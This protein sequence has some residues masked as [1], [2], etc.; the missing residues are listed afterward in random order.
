MRSLGLL[1]LVF[2]FSTVCA[3]RL[4]LIPLDS[5]PSSLDVPQMMADTTAW[6]VV[7]PPEDLLGKFL[8]PGNP[9][10][11]IAWLRQGDFQEGDVLIVSADML[12]YGGLVASR[13]PAVAS[14]TALKRLSILQEIK[15]RHPRITIYVFSALMRT[16]PTATSR[17]REWRDALTRYVELEDRYRRTKNQSLLPTLRSLKA[18]IPPDER[19]RYFLA[20]AR[21]MRVHHEL[22]KMVQGK[23]IDY[24]VIGADDARAYG[25]QYQELTELKSAAEQQGIGGKVYFL[26]GID[27]CGNLLISRAVLRRMD[28]TPQVWV[29]YSDPVRAQTRTAYEMHPLTVV[30]RD[31]VLASGARLAPSRDSSDYTLFIHTPEAGESSRRAFLQRLEQA[32]SRGEKVAIADVSAEKGTTDP[33]IVSQVFSPQNDFSQV[34]AYA[35]WNTAGNTLGL[36]VS[37][38]NIYWNA[39]KHNPD[40]L[41]RETAHL[42]FLFHRYIFDY[43]F[44]TVVRPVAFDV[45]SLEENENREHLSDGAL[46]RLQTFVQQTLERIIQRAYSEIFSRVTIGRDGVRYRVAK[47]ENLSVSLPWNRVWE[48]RVRF[49]VSL[50]LAEN[51]KAPVRDP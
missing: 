18:K 20:R 26:D 16:A 23:T 34:L 2:G 47:V 21:N 37:Q 25:P 1:A 14:A 4:F 31:Q 51:L 43:A 35:G 50:E 45:V 49:D 29:E 42:K 11:I 10:G 19:E 12:A 24:L 5:R 39:L 7:L 32:L 3:E 33:Q 48:V 38:A 28:V 27:Q 13:V 30:V 40:P 8:E 17:N 44:N 41:Q 22:L 9:E 36:S 46:Q 15:Q 6:K